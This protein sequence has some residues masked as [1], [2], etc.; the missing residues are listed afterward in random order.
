MCVQFTPA[1]VE[2]LRSKTGMDALMTNRKSFF[3]WVSIQ[4]ALS[5]TTP[6]EEHTNI[7][8]LII[9]KWQVIDTNADKEKVQCKKS[10]LDTKHERTLSSHYLGHH[11]Q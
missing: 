11:I 8:R 7:G 1:A 10:A 9:L 6:P 4:S 2:F 5:Y 3:E